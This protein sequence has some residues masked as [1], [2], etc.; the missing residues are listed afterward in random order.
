MEHNEEIKISLV[1]LLS[2]FIHI[3]FSLGF[4][5]PA[6]HQFLYY[7]SLRERSEGEG[8]DIIVNVNQD[9]KKVVND[10]TLLS[11]RD[12]SARGFIT[13]KKGDHWLNNSRDFAMKKGSYSQGR[14]SEASRHMKNKTGNLVT[15]NTNI[16]INLMRE[17]AGSLIGRYGSED[18]T[19]I[20]DRN[21][22]QRE[23]SIFY[24]NDGTFSFNTQMFKPFHYFKNMKDKIAGNWY[25]PLLANSVIVGYSPF[26]GSYTPGRLRIM[27]IPS[28]MVKLYFTMNRNGDIIDVVI[29]DSLGNKSLDASCLDAIKKSKSFGKVPPEI[30]GDEILIQFVFLYIVN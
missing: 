17:D 13:R 21:S 30:K 3:I 2:L 5:F 15:D 1:I 9:D 14:F 10:K 23:N 20:P 4:F 16:V 18:F 7:S 28:Q 26:T 27:A 6:Y 12:S 22:F 24:S 25:P 8:R 29:V 11:D 19:K